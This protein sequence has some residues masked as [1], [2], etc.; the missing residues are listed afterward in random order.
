MTCEAC[1][2]EQDHGRF[3]GRCGARSAPPEPAPDLAREETAAVTSDDS[4]TEGEVVGVSSSPTA[5][6]PL[7]AGV[8]V[9]VAVLGIAQLVSGGGDDV[10]PQ[11]SP[12]ATSPAA[13]AT[14]S[15]VPTSPKQPAA[16]PTPVDGQA[17]PVELNEPSETVLLFDDGHDGAF[18]VDLDTQ[19]V[20]AVDLPGQRAGDQQFRL[21]QMGGWIVVGWEEI[22]AVA[23]GSEQEP[24]KLADATVSLPASEPDQLWLINHASGRTD[25]PS[26]WTLV[27]ASGEPLVTT[28]R[29]AEKPIR[30]V[31]GGLAL[32]RD[33]GSL[34]KY[35]LDEQRVV[36]YLG[37][38][39]ADIA[40]VTRNRVAW[41]EEPCGALTVSDPDGR[42]VAVFDDAARFQPQA[43]WL[44][45]GGEHL[46]AAVELAY[47]DGAIGFGFRLYHVE[48][49]QVVEES[50][51]PLG[52]VFG[53][54]SDAGR[55]FYWVKPLDGTAA[56]VVF[57]WWSGSSFA[58]FTVPPPRWTTSAYGFLALPAGPNTHLFDTSNASTAP[59]P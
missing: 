5:G 50:T 42:Q 41:C 29:R 43:T 26:A 52:H 58:E 49:G 10:A 56:P 18:A 57:G 2:H 44:S 25:A 3:C 1:G 54:W 15:P 13:V 40:D 37:D 38:G 30:G 17:W 47:D 39:A 55:F 7:L 32:R 28:G 8:A 59:T 9:V 53:D 45:D 21:W 33:D 11:P 34:A 23:P 36:D 24:R 4:L 22:F 19:R 48:T 16:V 20:I 27:D 12:S 35:D 31:P 51:L 46:A 6:W 14:S